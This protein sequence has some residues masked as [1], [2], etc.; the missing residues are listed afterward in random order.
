MEKWNKNDWQGRSKENVEFS[1]K[2][3]LG[4]IAIGVVVLLFYVLSNI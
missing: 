4:S 3:V 2:V 1:Y